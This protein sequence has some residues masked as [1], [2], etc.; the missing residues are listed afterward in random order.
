MKWPLALVALWAGLALGQAGSATPVPRPKPRPAMTD[1]ATLAAAIP[2]PIPRLRPP[3]DKAASPQSQGQASSWP[4][5]AS[6]WSAESVSQARARC[7]TL[8]GP[9]DITYE[10]LAPIGAEG[11]CGAPA[12]I[13][14]TR[15]AGVT[16]EPAAILTCDMAAELHGWINDTVQPAAM[17]RLKTS[18]TQIHAAAS[19]VCRLRNNARTGKLSEHGRAN[20]LDMSGFSFAKSA[21]VTVKDD[22]WGGGVLAAIGLS[23]SGSFL[24]DIRAGACGHFT[25]VL[26][27]G[28][29][30]YHG[31][32]FH[33]DVLQRKGGYRICK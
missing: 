18:V 29:D 11:G 4:P 32:H 26:G 7:A 13:S 1:A 12:P 10:L 16:V 30:P 2:I 19:Y 6:G 5:P 14:V 33:V 24:G 22:S 15:I 31:D 25:T 27:A 21:A 3:R 28:S 23:K 9:L 17:K 20:A 8:V